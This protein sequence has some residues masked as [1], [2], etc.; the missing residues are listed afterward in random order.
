M[1][2]Q[3]A[4]LQSFNNELVKG[5]EDLRERREAVVL[6]IRQEEDRKRQLE[7]QMHELAQ[8]LERVN[9]SL[10]KKYAMRKE[11]DRVI[12]DTDMAYMK[13]VESSQTLLQILKQESEALP[14]VS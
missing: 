12:S 7:S 3:A 14:P 4:K 11:F 9:Q 8:Q 2:A 6:Q 5:I 1:S 13:I 10:T